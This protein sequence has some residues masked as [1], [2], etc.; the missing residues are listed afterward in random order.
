M[1][2]PHRRTGL[3]LPRTRGDGPR[4]RAVAGPVAAASPHTRGWTP[5]PVPIDVQVCGFPA[6]AGMDPDHSTAVASLARASPHTRGWTPCPR[7][8]TSS[9][10][11][12]P[13]HAGMDPSDRT[14]TTCSERLPRTR[15]DG[16]QGSTV[17]RSGAGL[18]RTRGDGPYG[19]IVFNPTTEA[20]PHTRGWTPRR[21]GGLRGKGGF[22]AH[23][24]MDRE[25]VTPFAIS[26]RLPRTRG[27]G[28]AG[29]QAAEH[30]RPASPHTRGWTLGRRRNDRRDQG[31]PAHAGMDPERYPSDPPN[32]R[33]PRTRGDGPWADYDS[34]EEAAA[35]PHTRGWTLC[36]R[37]GDSGERGFPAHAGM[38]PSPTCSYSSCSWLPRTR[39]DGPTR[40]RP[41]IVAFRASPHTRGWTLASGRSASGRTGFPA[42]AGMDPRRLPLWDG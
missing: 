12:F 4:P 1:P 36:S 31:F 35:S 33:L 17:I 13:A 10:T 3:W 20:S 24:G 25:S 5:C 7:R 42:H 28:P 41:M 26:R 39:G 19:Q 15:G 18:P 27:D 38:D 23:A 6:H 37:A 9:S 8:C 21:S 32:P 29:A 16:P 11:G 14:H 22:P 40:M 34:I 30:G 2:S